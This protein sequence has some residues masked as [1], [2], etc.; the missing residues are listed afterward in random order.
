[1]ADE[2]SGWLAQP[3]EGGELCSMREMSFRENPDATVLLGPP[4]QPPP[5]DIRKKQLPP[6][7][8]SLLQSLQAAQ[9]PREVTQPL[10]LRGMGGAGSGEG[11]CWEEGSGSTEA[12]RHQ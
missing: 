12:W 7:I 9:Q 5:G 2:R 8:P 6:D 4:T 3:G 1:M 11:G 10:E